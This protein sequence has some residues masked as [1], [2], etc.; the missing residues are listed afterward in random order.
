HFIPTHKGISLITILPEI[1]Q[2]PIL[3]AEWEEKLKQIE[4]GSL[5]PD[6]FLQEINEMIESLVRTY[7]VIKGTDNLFPSNK[8]GI[9]KCPRCGGNVIENRKVFCCRNK[10]CAFALWKEN[11]FFTMKKK[12]LTKEI[13]IKLL[14]E[15]RV[16]LTGCYSEKTGKTY[17]AIVILDDNGGKYIN[18]KIEFP[19]KKGR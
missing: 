2:S 17:D 14:K 3:T 9:G 15:G 5:S 10:D 16:K 1:I 13:A 19:A 12:T 4:Q 18:F 7:E 6:E 8:E 11:K